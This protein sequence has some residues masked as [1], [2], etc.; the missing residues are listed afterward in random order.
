MF[1]R[2]AERNSDRELRVKLFDTAGEVRGKTGS[3]NSRQLHRSARVCA[4]S[5]VL[6]A[7]VVEHAKRTQELTRTKCFQL[8]QKG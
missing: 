2:K 8:T 1:V 3:W 7:N 5:M 4:D 6:P